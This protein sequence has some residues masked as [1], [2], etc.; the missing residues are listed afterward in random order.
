MKKISHL[1]ES[2]F[3]TSALPVYLAAQISALLYTLLDSPVFLEA[4]RRDHILIVNGWLGLWFLLFLAGLVTILLLVIRHGWHQH[5]TR[6]IRAKLSISYFMGLI[7]SLLT[8]G[9]RF[10]PVTTPAFFISIG[11]LA[12]LASTIYF[13]WIKRA[14]A[15][16]IIFP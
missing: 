8:L 13:I 15:A 12:L 6:Q 7:A 16:E 5:L 11:A 10:M 2:Q 14:Q 4:Y 9:L 1:K 3:I